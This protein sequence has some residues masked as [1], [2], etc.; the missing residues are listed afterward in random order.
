MAL[1]IAMIAWRPT[2]PLA[3]TAQGSRASETYERALKMRQHLHDSSK[4]TPGEYR[5][6]IAMFQSVYRQDPAFRKSP[7]ALLAAAEL[8]AGMGRDQADERCFAEAIKAYEL[9]VTQYPGGPASRE[10]LFAQGK[11]YLSD[12]EEPSHARQIFE[13]L[14]QIYPQAPESREA[15][16]LL[17]GLQP[18]ANAHSDLPAAAAPGIVGSRGE[19]N[20]P[21][22]DKSD[23]ADITASHLALNT[24]NPNEA[25]SQTKR[26]S[27]QTLKG[28][29]IEVSGIHYWKGSGY[30]RIIINVSGEVHFSATQVDNPDRLVFDIDHSLLTRGLGD[31]A[32]PIGDAIVRQVRMGQFQPEV[33]RAVIEVGRFSRYTAYTIPNPYRLIIDLFDDSSPDSH[34]ETRAAKN[35]ETAAAPAIAKVEP[36]IA[37]KVVKHLPAKRPATGSELPGDRHDSRPAT[38]PVPTGSSAELAAASPAAYPQQPVHAVRTEARKNV[39]QIAASHSTLS[40]GDAHAATL[41]PE[42]SRTEA[43]TIVPDPPSPPKAEPKTLPVPPP[44]VK[45]PPQMK[46]REQSVPEAKLTPFRP[47]APDALG[48]RSLTRALGLKIGRIV[49]DPGHGGHDNG[50]VGP[51]GLREKDLVLDVGLRLQHLLETKTQ[52]EVVM[53]RSDDTFIPLEERTAIANSKGADLFLSIHANSSPEPSARGIETFYLNFTNDPHAIEVAARENAGSNE[54]VH[55]LQSLIKQIAL[56]EKVRE[57]HE[58]AQSVQRE[59]YSATGKGN[60]LMQDRGVKKAPFV[61]LIGANM[62][63]VL[64][65]ISFVSNPRDERLLRKPEYREKIAEALFR[66]VQ[67]YTGN[68]GGIRVAQRSW[69]TH[70]AEEESGNDTGP[71]RVL[72]TSAK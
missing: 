43:P 51:H 54:S 31:H 38:L 19:V 25:A 28:Q 64:T 13:H 35:E 34:Q 41:N 3:A 50:T 5:K 55:E 24:K 59:V 12:L 27:G 32:L 63:S 40:L 62:P 67:R 56:T 1:L 66:G 14:I 60:G 21:H 23:A 58:F 46:S 68:F 49:I 22:T 53:T 4:V 44:V 70:S 26:A 15:R 47:A 48:S 65:E 39:S 30:T 2:P 61:V 33:T 36:G 72:A 17:A 16:K 52:A 69:L 71:A 45:T 9:V 10:A 18:T 7:A 20:T 11:I 8:Y 37:T 29:R 6:V 42:A 57:S